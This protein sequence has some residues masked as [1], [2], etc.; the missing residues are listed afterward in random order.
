MNQPDPKDTANKPAFSKKANS[1]LLRNIRPLGSQTADVL[2]RDGIIQQIGAEP[3]VGQVR[4]RASRS[5]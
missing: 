5:T 1:F 3:F 2:A 4:L